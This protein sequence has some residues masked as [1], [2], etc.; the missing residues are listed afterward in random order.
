V[1]NKDPC[2]PARSFDHHRTASRFSRLAV[3]GSF[4]ANLSPMTGEFAGLG[5]D[6][7]ENAQFV[8]IDAEI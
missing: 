6:P 7:F 8:W 1:A 3:T 5:V 2:D 4:G